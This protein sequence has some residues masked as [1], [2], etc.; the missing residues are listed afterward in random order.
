VVAEWLREE[1]GVEVEEWTGDE[2]E[3]G[4]PAERP[5]QLTLF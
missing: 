2:A 4:K 3:D 5:E 1:A